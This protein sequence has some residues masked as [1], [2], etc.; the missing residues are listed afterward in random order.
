MRFMLSEQ[1]SDYGPT[2]NGFKWLAKLLKI[3]VIIDHLFVHSCNYKPL[4]FEVLRQDEPVVSDHYPILG[5]FELKE[6]STL[7]T[8]KEW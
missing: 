6:W 5:H 1:D 8:L 7:P 2:F 4:K 3:P